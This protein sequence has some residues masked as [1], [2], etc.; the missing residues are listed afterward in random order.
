MHNITFPT[1][2]SDSHRPRPRLRPRRP[3]PPQVVSYMR[4]V[5][6]AFTSLEQVWDRC[7][8]LKAWAPAAMATVKGKWSRTKAK[9]HT[10]MSRRAD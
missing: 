5:C 2:S 1:V 6:G 9:L 4:D 10:V 8:F 3:L 7:M